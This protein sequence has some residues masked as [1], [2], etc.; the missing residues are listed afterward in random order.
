MLR[1]IHHILIDHLFYPLALST[2]LSLLFLFFRIYYFDHYSYLF[3]FWNLF[4]A[5][6]PYGC[7]LLFLYLQRHFSIK[8]RYLSP[9]FFIWLFFFPNAPYILTDFWHLRERAPV[10]LW[11][12]IGLLL[13]FSWSGCL[14]AFASLNSIQD[15]LDKKV[16]KI[17][18]WFF[19]STVL[20]LSGLGIYLGR[21]LRWN[22]WDLL[23][24]PTLLFQELFQK[25]TDSEYH[26]QVI[27]FTT[28]FSLI[29]ATNYFVFRGIQKRKEV[30]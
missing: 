1:K 2:L 11:Y 27:G 17:I 3:L 30:E 10:P 5:W 20:A 9:L 21:F 25:L 12:D 7:S 22:S 14:L 4:L 15:L 8:W 28:M 23:T 6:I 24:K 16:G 26:P 18:S 13:A 19:V 29:L